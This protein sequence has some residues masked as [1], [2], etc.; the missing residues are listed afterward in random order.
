MSTAVSPIRRNPWLLLPL[1][2]FPPLAHLWI[3]RAL[4]G[5]VLA[6]GLLVAAA[7][8]GWS[9]LIHQ[10]TGML[11]MAGVIVFGLLVIQVDAQFLNFR[12]HGRSRPYARA[13]IVLLAI[14]AY[15]ALRLFL[16]PLLL[17]FNLYSIPSMSMA[18]TLLPGDMI[19]T[20]DRPLAAGL[21]RRGRAVVFVPPHRPTMVYVQ[22]IVGLAGDR[23]QLIDGILWVNNVR[24]DE[25]YL[26][27]HRSPRAVDFRNFGPIVVP[28]GTVLTLGDNR[29]NSED[30]RMFGPVPVTNIRCFPTLIVHSERADRTGINPGFDQGESFAGAA[31]AIT[32]DGN[33]T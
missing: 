2:L 6:A 24:I 14:P 11:A 33:G 18:P 19:M 21:V 25:T 30:G 4:R 20:D 17:G 8:V 5:C 26:S 10:P 1:T 29:D 31:E 23:V 9:G 32:E 22:R 3:G 12:S 13:W 28:P 27:P 15:L 16:A 7:S